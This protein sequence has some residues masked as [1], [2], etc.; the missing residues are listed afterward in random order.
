MKTIPRYTPTHRKNTRELLIL[1]ILSMALTGA[2]II[3]TGCTAS[4]SPDGTFSIGTTAKDL[5]D[6]YKAYREIHATK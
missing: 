1:L 3:L 5:Q 2:L 6:V 4:M